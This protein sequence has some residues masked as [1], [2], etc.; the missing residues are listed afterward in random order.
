MAP[1]LRGGKAALRRLWRLVAGPS[2]R[3]TLLR[4]GALSVLAMVGGVFYAWLGL[5]PI[6]ASSG[7]WAVTD[8]FLHFAMRNA[9][10]TRSLGTKAPPLDDPALILRG[11]GHYATGCVPCHGAPGEP[12]AVVAAAMTPAPPLLRPK[13]ETW[14]PGELFWI[15]RHGIKF[16][17][18][19]AWPAQERADEVW[20]MVA[21]ISQLP[22]LTPTRYRDLAFGSTTPP[23]GNGMGTLSEP[24]QTALA[25]CARCHGY[26]G[27]GRGK[28]AFPLLAGQKQQYLLESLRAFAAGDRH[29]GFMEAAA[30]GLDD[31]T[32]QELARYYAELPPQLSREPTADVNQADRGLAERG[33]PEQGIPACIECHGAGEVTRSPVYPYLGG[34][35]AGYLEQQ[36]NLFKRG[37]R[38]GTAY[39]HIMQAIAKRLTPQQIEAA[40]AYF[41]T[42]ERVD[43]RSATSRE[44]PP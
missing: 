2:G 13:I 21:F 18:M 39:A 25:N 11:A 3:R 23:L 9:V 31:E 37:V 36:L 20:A 12:Q 1:I 27:A 29:S 5:A 15:V 26:D 43:G 42:H 6:A 30:S 44:P 19:P 33:V 32:L 22:T 16:T 7:H 38:G 34:Q 24:T 40:A 17:A 14:Q 28:A 41:G 4:L 35:H 10:E 8:W